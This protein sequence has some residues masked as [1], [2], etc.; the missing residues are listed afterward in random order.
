ME[1]G[2]EEHCTTLDSQL[3]P[4]TPANKRRAMDFL[5]GSTAV[6]STDPIP[7]LEA[8]FRQRPQVIYLLT[9]GD[10]PDNDAVLRRICQLNKG[11]KPASTPSPS[12]APPIPT[13][14]S[15]T[16]S[17]PSPERTGERSNM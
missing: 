7:G 8:A 16:C 15:S 2:T 6:G 12:W 11:G 4:A 10:F 3:L 17:K 5:E 9:D 14:P 1:Q 13:P